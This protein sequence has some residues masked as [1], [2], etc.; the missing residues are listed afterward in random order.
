MIWWS[1]KP[2]FQGGLLI[3]WGEFQ[4]KT[5]VFFLVVFLAHGG[6]LRQRLFVIDSNVALYQRR[7]SF[8][9]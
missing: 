8:T 3:P 5:W 7:G 9:D 2:V 1:L 4:D 6:A